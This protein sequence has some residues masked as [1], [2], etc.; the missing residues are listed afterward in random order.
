MGE[1]KESIG[2]KHTRV[3]CT[4]MKG[5]EQ[6]YYERAFEY[7]KQ[8]ADHKTYKTQNIKYNNKNYFSYKHRITVIF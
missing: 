2:R 3:K 1:E 5:V 4:K 8:A 6:S 7:Y